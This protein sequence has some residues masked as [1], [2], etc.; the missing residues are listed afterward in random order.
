MA[1]IPV[2][3]GIAILDTSYL[4]ELYQVPGCC[5]QSRFHTVRMQIDDIINAGGELFVTVPVLFEVANHIT[6]VRDGRRRRTLSGKFRDDVKESIDGNGPWT[7]VATGKDILLRSEDIIRLADRFLQASG[8]NY[9]FADISIIDLAV[10]LQGKNRAVE[11]LTFDGQ[12]AAYS[13]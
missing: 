8:E 4:L 2:L 9:S 1:G 3:N 5:K 13:G 12:P 7:I 10:T 11:I 6:H